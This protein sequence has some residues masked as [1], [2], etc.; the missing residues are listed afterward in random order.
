[1]CAEEDCALCAF[2]CAKPITHKAFVA[3]AESEH[4]ELTRWHDPKEELPEDMVHVLVKKES[5][6]FEVAF[7]DY[8]MKSW[9]G[10]AS[11]FE[12]VVGWREIHE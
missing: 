3:G 11:S 8:Q 1:M 10:I 7:Y 12:E 6:A 5:G 4:A 2:P 9:F